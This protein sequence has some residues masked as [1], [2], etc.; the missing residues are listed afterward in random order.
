MFVNTI[1][2]RLARSLV[3]RGN[4]HFVRA[5]QTQSLDEVRTERFILDSRGFFANTREQANTI[6]AVTRLTHQERVACH[7]D[8][9]HQI[10]TPPAE[11]RRQ[12]DAKCGF[13][14]QTEPTGS[15]RERA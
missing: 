7:V 6:A 2:P 11:I 15:N 12:H 14:Q 1:V 13:D 4:T 10:I 5:A 3:A 9:G 8:R